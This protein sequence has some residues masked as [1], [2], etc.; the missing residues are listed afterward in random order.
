MVVPKTQ[1]NINKLFLN[2]N[3]VIACLIGPGDI[4]IED[5]EMTSDNRAIVEGVK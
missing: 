2:K 1:K 3:S 5:I 4:E